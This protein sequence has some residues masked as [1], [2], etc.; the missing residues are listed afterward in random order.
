MTLEEKLY[1]ELRSTKNRI[2][3]IQLELIDMRKA[4]VYDRYKAITLEIE[5]KGL[6]SV[7]SKLIH[8]GDRSLW[9]ADER[10]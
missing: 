7:E 8:L 6:E 10:N 1:K 9:T 5:L 2:V 4:Q 3:G